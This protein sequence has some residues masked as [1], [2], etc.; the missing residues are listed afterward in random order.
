MLHTFV[1]AESSSDSVGLDKPNVSETQPSLWL[2]SRVGGVLA[3]TEVT[4]SNGALEG[5]NNKSK[6]ISH[7]AFGFRSAP[8]F[9]AA[10]SCCAR[11][12]L[13]EET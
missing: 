3:W 12:P 2:R 11:L 6:S 8:N 4:L 7:R 5:I 10:I 13:P 1:K 9:I